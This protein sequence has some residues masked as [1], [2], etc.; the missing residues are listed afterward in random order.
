MLTI[1]TFKR[2]VGNALKTAFELLKIIIPVYAVVTILNHTPVIG[3]ISRLFQPLMSL[4]GLP[5][6]AA[7]ALVVAMFVNVYTAIGIIIAL[8]MTVWQITIIGVMINFAHELIVE[9]AVLKKTGVKIWPVLLVRLGGAFIA[10]FALNLV[11]QMLA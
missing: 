3:W 8:N 2:G 1:G 5:G 10:G 7:L 4:V 9:T 6:E 11:Q